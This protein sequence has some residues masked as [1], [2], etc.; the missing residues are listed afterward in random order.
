LL[1]V[2]LSTMKPTYQP[3]K[4]EIVNTSGQWLYVK[5]IYNQ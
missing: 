5:L 4:K 3:E 2:A 1:K